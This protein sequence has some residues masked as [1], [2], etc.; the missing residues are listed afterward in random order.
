MRVLKNCIKYYCHICIVAVSAGF[1]GRISFSHYMGIDSFAIEIYGIEANKLLSQ[2][3]IIATL[4]KCQ[5][6]TNQGAVNV[7]IYSM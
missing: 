6:F 5:L 2:F 1:P 3:V 4:E 7:R